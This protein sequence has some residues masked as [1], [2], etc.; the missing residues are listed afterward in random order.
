MKKNRTEKSLFFSLLAFINAAL[1]FLFE[2]VYADYYFD[3]AD[4]VVLFFGCVNLVL[5]CWFFNR[6]TY[7]I[8]TTGRVVGYAVDY[9][10]NNKRSSYSTPYRITLN[11]EY[12]A[13][14]A[15]RQSHVTGSDTDFKR[16]G[17]GS[18]LRIA[19]KP[20]RPD[21]IIVIRQLFYVQLCIIVV[22]E[23]LFFLIWIIMDL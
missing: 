17:R 23:L 19:Y 5:T 15:T 12:E 11:I 4:C 9:T 20:G 3:F 14:G 22:L 7:T 16:C 13:N 10:F 1:L 18:V 2:L 21:K 6:S 8:K